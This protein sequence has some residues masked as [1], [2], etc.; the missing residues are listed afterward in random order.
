[1]TAGIV[2]LERVEAGSGK[3]QTDMVYLTYSIETIVKRDETNRVVR[4]NS[5]LEKV[6]VQ[7]RLVN[8]WNATL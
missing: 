8:M 5:E 3:K 7:T 2:D 1:M 4:T 6:K